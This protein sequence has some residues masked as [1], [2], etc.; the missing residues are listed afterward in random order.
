LQGWKTFGWR[1]DWRVRYLWFRDR[2]AL[3]TQQLMALGY[4]VALGLISRRF[5]LSVLSSD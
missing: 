2:K 1:G 5:P 4:I 3:F